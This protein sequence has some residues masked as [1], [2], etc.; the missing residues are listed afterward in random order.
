MTEKHREVMFKLGEN[1]EGVVNLLLSF[2]NK[3]ILAKGD[4]NGTML[5]SDTIDMDQAYMEIVGMSKEELVNRQRRNSEKYEQE[6][7]KFAEEIPEL[8]RIWRR[9]GR[10]VLEEDK[11]DEWDSI[12]PIRLRDIYQ[13]IE[14]RQCL[15][16][17]SILN[18]GGSLDE[19]K[20]VMESQGHS[21]FSFGLVC[22]MIENFCNR[23]K[24][25]VDYVK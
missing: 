10:D 24:T 6:K 23:G 9:K 4:F 20:K 21:G 5:Y 19:A 14:L 25:F 16:V 2:K 17:I 13:G 1:L 7:K 11:W 3:G 15:E 8:S 22:S 12:V 18:E